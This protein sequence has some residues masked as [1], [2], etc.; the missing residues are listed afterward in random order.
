VAGSGSAA[1][2]GH[3]TTAASAPPI[4]VRDLRFLGFDKDVVGQGQD[5]K[6]N[7]ERDTHIREVLR[8]GNTPTFDTHDPATYQTITAPTVT[9]RSII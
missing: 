1:Q 7:G 5:A 6:P 9:H 4:V 2:A 3:T 8:C